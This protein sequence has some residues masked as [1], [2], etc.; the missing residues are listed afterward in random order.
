MDDGMKPGN[1]IIVSVLLFAILI[2]WQLLFFRNAP[3]KPASQPQDTA[4]TSVI[5]EVQQVPQNIT[6]TLHCDTLLCVKTPLYSAAFSSSG[7][8]ISYKVARVGYLSDIE[9]LE[10]GTVAWGDRGITYILPVNVSKNYIVDSDSL[11]ISLLSADGTVEK[12]LTFYPDKYLIGVI[13]KGVIPT[14]EFSG[15]MRFTE[16]NIKQES[17][18]YSYVIRFKNTVKMPLSKFKE[19]KEFSLDQVVWF[20]IRTKYF[21][22]GILNSRDKGDVSFSTGGVSFKN[23]SGNIRIYLG[24]L[25]YSVLKRNHSDLATAFDFGSPIIKPFSMAIYSLMRSLHKFIPNYGWVVV[26]FALI[27]KIIF[28]PLTRNTVLASKRMQELKPKLDTLQKLYKDNPQKLQQEM[29]ELYKK[30]K[31]NPFSGCLTLLIQMPIFFALYQILSYSINLKGTPFILWIKDLSEK[32]P[33][34]ILPILMGVTS[35]LLSRMQQQ[36]T[37]AQ[38]KML[39]YMMPLLMVFIFISL[40]SGIVL[41]WL[42]F[43]IF[44]IFE[45]LLI[46][47]LEGHHGT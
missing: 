34:Y 42:T 3:Q 10:Q 8:I 13:Y 7:G 14:T 27:M 36:A 33:Y 31:V 4:K 26:F 18:I 25:D 16:K 28:F 45:A 23:A 17:S 40:P 22:S 44:G 9:L 19:K 15:K 20:G 37:D 32:D 21:F 41:Y 47:R 2:I 5:K 30:Y 12:V 38:S 1:F 24:P 43:N 29:M 6:D 11:T 35:I 46:K 39:M